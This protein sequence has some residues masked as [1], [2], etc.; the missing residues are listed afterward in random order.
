M[1]PKDKKL[2]EAYR[3]CYADLRESMQGGEEYDGDACS[4][5]T[6]AMINYASKL[7][8]YDTATNPVMSNEFMAN[9]NT[10]RVPQFQDL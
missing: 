6:T 1:W 7:I 8:A 10:P 4:Q 2:L 5:E 3:K 9:A